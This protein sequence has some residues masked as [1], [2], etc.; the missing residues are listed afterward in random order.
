MNSSEERRLRRKQQLADIL[1]E[2]PDY[3]QEQRE[4]WE[5]AWSD[6]VFDN[7]DQSCLERDLR[8]TVWI[9][10]KAKASPSYAQ[11]IY[12]A[13]CN[14][15]WQKLDVLPILK[16]EVWSCTWRHAG[17]IVADMIEQG[18]YLDWYCSGMG[19]DGNGNGHNNDPDRRYAAEGHITDEIREDFARLGWRPFDNAD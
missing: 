10:D 14:Q 4:A 3:T 1:S 2:I 9:C 8:S 13:L 19:P 17:G 5:R 18:D 11:N 6:P 7:P 15:E 12:A 16:D